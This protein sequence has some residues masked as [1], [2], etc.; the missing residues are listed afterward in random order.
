MCDTRNYNKVSKRCNVQPAKEK[1]GLTKD[2][3]KLVDRFRKLRKSKKQKTP[4]EG[5]LQVADASE[6]RCL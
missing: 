3:R 4:T 2:R 1:T 5:K 6:G